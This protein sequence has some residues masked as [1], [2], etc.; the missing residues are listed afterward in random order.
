[1]KTALA[2]FGGIII[3]WL[4]YNAINKYLVEKWRQQDKYDRQPYQ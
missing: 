4:A 2:W 3:A 1:M